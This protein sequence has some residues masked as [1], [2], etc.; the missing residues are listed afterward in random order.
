MIICGGFNMLAAFLWILALGWMCMGLLWIFPLTLGVWEVVIGI[1]VRKGIPRPTVRIVSIL[2]MLA[3]LLTC[4]PL[5]IIL[6]VVVLSLLTSKK[7]DGFL[8]GDS[9]PT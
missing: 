9:H 5:S 4:N 2:G 1:A 3:S 7:M 8:D 6:E